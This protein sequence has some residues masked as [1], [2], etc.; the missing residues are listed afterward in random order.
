MLLDI[1]HAT[2]VYSI[3]E[4]FRGLELPRKDLKIGP[5]GSSMTTTLH[6]SSICVTIPRYTLWVE[7]TVP[8]LFLL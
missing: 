2:L 6:L 3:F 7:K 8:L 1:S 4:N 5:R